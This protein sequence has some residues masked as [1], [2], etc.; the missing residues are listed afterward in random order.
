MRTGKNDIIELFSSGNGATILV[1]MKQIVGNVLKQHIYEN[2]VDTYKD[3]YIALMDAEMYIA[4]MDNLVE[5]LT[6]RRFTQILSYEHTTPQYADIVKEL[7]TAVINSKLYG[8]ALIDCIQYEV[9]SIADDGTLNKEYRYVI[10]TIPQRDV[11][12]VGKQYALNKER[13][14]QN[15][16]YLQTT[17]GGIYLTILYHSIK[18]EFAISNWFNA[19]LQRVSV[20]Y[21][22][23]NTQGIAND[24]ELISGSNPAV[25]N[26]VNEEKANI[27]FITEWIATQLQNL[28]NGDLITTTQNLDIGHTTLSDTG[29]GSDLKTF[30]DQMATYIQIAIIG[31]SGDTTDTQ[32][33]GSYARSKQMSLVTDAI[34]WADMNDCEAAVSKAFKLLG[35]D[36]EFKFIVDDTEYSTQFLDTIEKLKAMDLVTENGEQ[37]YIDTDTLLKNIGIVSK[38][39][40][41]QKIYLGT[42]KTNTIEGVNDGI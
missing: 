8:K 1:R 25:V 38:D 17:I 2:N 29:V 26:A 15:P 41:N 16:I 24:I 31:Q 40:P 4:R 30:I 42:P 11:I 37:L 34:K 7:C 20:N 23:I 13:P 21:A 10:D 9:Q 36:E 12:P 3:D 6:E 32:S 5:G 35:I 27:T 14:L 39:M 19:L 28:S 18:K 33:T 22:K